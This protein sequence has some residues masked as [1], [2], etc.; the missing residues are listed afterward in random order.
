MMLKLVIFGLAGLVG[1]VLAIVVVGFL[2]PKQHVASRALVL[3]QKPED[4]FALISD[5][6]SAPTWRSEVRQVELL[7][8][9]NE[10]ARFREIGSTG[11][12]TMEVTQWNPPRRMVTRI[13]DKGLP[14]GGSWIFEIAP[15]AGGCQLNITERGE[16]YNPVFRFVSRFILGYERTLNTYL[17]SVSRK[18]GENTTP[19]PGM[20]TTL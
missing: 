10:H 17:Q 5:F 6:K 4:V 20:A 3:R 2:I 7:P 13:A 8:E 18:F 19:M 15:T 16:I 1:I 12:L 9:A 14:F 11:A